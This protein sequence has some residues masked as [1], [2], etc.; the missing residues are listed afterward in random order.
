M[1]AVLG[2]SR[3]PRMIAEHLVDIGRQG[4]QL[5]SVLSRADGGL[6]SEGRVRQRCSW[7]LGSPLR[8]YACVRGTC[9]DGVCEV[10]EAPHCGCVADCPNAAWG[11]QDAGMA[12][13]GARAPTARCPTRHCSRMNTS[14]APLPPLFA[15]ERRGR[16]AD[17]HEEFCRWFDA[18]Q[19]GPL[20]DYERIGRDIWAEIRGTRWS[21]EPKPSP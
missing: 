11:P 2:S 9:G 7:V 8:V 21:G 5:P 12:T 10:G 15:A 3:R 16:W 18:D 1:L 6:L 4:R 17:S 13:D 14:V 20:E 19:A